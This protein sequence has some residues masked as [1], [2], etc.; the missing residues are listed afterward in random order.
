MWSA[1][2]N[3]TDKIPDSKDSTNIPI[4]D[5]TNFSQWYIQMKIHLCDED[6]LDVCEKSHPGD[7][8]VPATN[9]WTKASYDALNIIISRISECVFLEVI[10]SETTEKENLLWSKINEQYALKRGIKRGR[11]RMDWQK[12][13]YN[14]NLQNYID[15]CRK[16]LMELET[17]SI[18][19]PNE[20]LLYSLLGN[21]AGDSNLLQLVESVT[22]NE[23]LIQ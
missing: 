3:M 21:L 6:L 10:N 17:V 16:L 4:L 14:G 9:K 5:G 15:S 8:T 12:C 20:L 2:F 1:R 19:M 7:A 13:F 11:T 23:E 18:K 22:L